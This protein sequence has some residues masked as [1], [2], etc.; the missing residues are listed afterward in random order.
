MRTQYFD[1]IS[2]QA[3]GG[4]SNGFEQKKLLTQCS[5][6]DLKEEKSVETSTTL[7]YLSTYNKQSTHY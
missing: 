3:K 1:G 7:Y 4:A 2:V 6:I 5:G